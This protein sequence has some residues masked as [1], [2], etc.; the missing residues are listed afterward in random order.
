MSQEHPDTAKVFDAAKTIVETLKGLD[1]THQERAIRFACESLGLGPTTQGQTLAPPSPVAPSS[2]P[3]SGRSSAA[4]AIDI[5]QFTA[6]K[7]PKSDQQFAAVVAYF[8]RF[9]A[10]EPQKKESIAAEDLTEAARLAGR[11]RPKNASF[12]LNNAKNAG[13]LDIAE[14]GR[15]RISTVGENLV[16]VTLPGTDTAKA[17][18]RK[19]A[20][21]KP[22]RQ[23]SKKT[24]GASKQK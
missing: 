10:P 16:A 1:K 21:K 14:R 9:E 5:K 3:P 17:S 23:T 2:A 11:R 7:A 22:T 4:H 6:A 24:G 19:T 15:Y 18:N 12:T 13:Y 8:Y 20:K